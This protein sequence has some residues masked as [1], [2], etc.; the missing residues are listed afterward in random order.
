VDNGTQTGVVQDHNLI[1]SAGEEN[2]RTY[3]SLGYYDETGTIK[4]YEYDKLSF[5]I[6]HDHNIGERLTIKPKIAL[7]YNTRESRQHSLYAMQTYMPWDSPYDAS[8]EIV[9]P[10][11]NG[12]PWIGRDKSN[13]LYDLQRNHGNSSVS[14]LFLYFDNEIGIASIK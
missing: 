7:N 3:I 2:S 5:R 1:F 10:Q 13:Y 11:E 9:N 4:G 14:T 12:V 6:N 8:G